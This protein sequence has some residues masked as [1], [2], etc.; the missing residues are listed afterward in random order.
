MSDQEKNGERDERAVNGTDAN[1]PVAKEEAADAVEILRKQLEEEKEKADSYLKSWQRTQADFINY[2]RRTEQE[3]VEQTKYANASLILK[4]LPVLDD[5][6]RA[7][8]NLPKQAEEMPWLDGIR[9]IDR[10]LRSIL[11]QAGVTPIEALGHDFDPTLHE[12][13]LFEEGTE[14]GQGKVIEELQKG[15]KL[16]DRVIRPTMVRVGQLPTAER[17]EQE[18]VANDRT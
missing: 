13:V 8:A 3:R 17:E 12:A 16:H 5:F 6:D 14:P 11:E 10:K 18:P 9:L 7:F 2:K 1:D 4:I 15:Y